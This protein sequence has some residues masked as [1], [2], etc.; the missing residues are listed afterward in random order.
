MP[1][2]IAESAPNNPAG[3]APLRKTYSMR[4]TSSIDTDWPAGFGT[5][6][7]MRGHARDLL[8]LSDFAHPQIIG[9]DH[10][11]I[12]APIQRE[13]MAIKTSRRDD[14]AQTLVGLRGGGHL[15]K[16]IATVFAD[17]Q[18]QAT[19][20][21]LLL[22]DYPGAS[23]VAG[24]AWSRWMANSFELRKEKGGITA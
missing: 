1:S 7:R 13:I 5:P 24:W 2:S 20:L 8:T 3:P 4:R 19:P 11:E 21:H 12:E 6:M 10:I 23:L 9:V 14:V 15:R 18:L 17:E 16:S 22:D